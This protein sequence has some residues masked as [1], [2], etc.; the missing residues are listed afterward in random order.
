MQCEAGDTNNHLPSDE[1]DNDDLHL[2][3]LAV[4][5]HLQEEPV[6]SVRDSVLVR[7][8]CDDERWNPCIV[9]RT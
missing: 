1:R 2:G 5:Q 9:I 8:W 3:G 7:I 6:E 4:L